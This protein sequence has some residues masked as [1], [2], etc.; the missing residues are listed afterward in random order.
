MF[1]M[2][3]PFSKTYQV[4][5]GDGTVKTVYKNVDHVFPLVIPGWKGSLAAA[6]K[7]LKGVNAE[8]EAKIS[9]LVHGYLFKLDDKNHSMMMSLR[10]AYVTYQSDPREYGEYLRR[11]VDRL[12]DEQR[13]LL[14]WKTKIDGLVELVKLH[15]GSSQVFDR[16]LEKFME[17]LGELDP[18]QAA[19]MSIEGARQTARD[20]LEE[21]HGD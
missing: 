21:N 7:A 6:G 1:R 13:R 15:P 4:K 20:M 3:W 18:S 14:M 5:Y 17:S 2:N 10:A 12:V 9:T 11:A 16:A 19:A 8:V